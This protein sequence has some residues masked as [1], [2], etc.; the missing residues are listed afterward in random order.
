MT[1]IK[2]KK[3]YIIT[4]K[5]SGIITSFYDANVSFNKT[6]KYLQKHCEKKS[7]GNG[8][9]HEQRVQTLQQGL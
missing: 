7:K 1:T 2:S 8:D 6:I 4:N 5:E 3:V 9:R